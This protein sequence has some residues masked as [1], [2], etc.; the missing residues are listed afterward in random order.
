MFP[1]I[2]KCLHISAVRDTENCFVQMAKLATETIVI[3]LKTT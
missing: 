2:N 3:V 1:S